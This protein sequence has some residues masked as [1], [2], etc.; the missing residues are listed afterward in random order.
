V[1]EDQRNVAFESRV[2]AVEGRTAVAR[3]SASLSS[4]SS[5]SR[6]ELDGVF[7]LVFERDDLCSELREWWHVRTSP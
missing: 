7:I 4:A 1:T 6:V 3:W 5:G 2:V